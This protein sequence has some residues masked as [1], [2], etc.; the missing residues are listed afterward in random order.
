MF[1]FKVLEKAWNEA[2]DL[3]DREH[4]TF[5]FWKRDKKFTTAMLDNKYDWG[6]YRITVDYKEDIELVRKIVKKLNKQGKFGYMN[7]VIDILKNNP[8]L[9][10]I[11]SMHTWGANW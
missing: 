8:E 10:K 4:V 5:Y 2:K 9:F 1:S 3:K 11:N 6:K 7:E